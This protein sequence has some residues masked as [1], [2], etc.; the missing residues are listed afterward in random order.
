MSDRRCS[1]IVNLPDKWQEDGHADESE[2][3]RFAESRREA[4]S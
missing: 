3:E 1:N 2:L 4:H